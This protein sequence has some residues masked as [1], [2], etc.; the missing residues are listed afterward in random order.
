MALIKCM[1]RKNSRLNAASSAARRRGMSFITSNRLFFAEASVLTLNNSLRH[2]PPTLE[3][4]NFEVAARRRTGALP[5]R[6][7]TIRSSSR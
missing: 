1:A 3:L 5:S 6:S 2:A 7:N 4:V